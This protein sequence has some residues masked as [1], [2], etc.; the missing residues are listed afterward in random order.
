V[1][2]KRQ[3]KQKT[4][5]WAVYHLTG[6]PAKFMGFIYDAPDEQTAIALA[7]EKYQVLPNERGRLIAKRRS[8]L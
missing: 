2:A 5:I 1:T 4:H 8:N 7:I 3:I 6:T